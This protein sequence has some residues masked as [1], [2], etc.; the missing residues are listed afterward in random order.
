MIVWSKWRLGA[1]CVRCQPPRLLV[2]SSFSE[3]LDATAVSWRLQ[4]CVEPPLADPDSTL[5]VQEQGNSDAVLDDVACMLGCTR[6]SLHGAL[7]WRLP[8]HALCAR[9]FVSL[10]AP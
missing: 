4:T 9:G 3:V 6:S 1:R 8:L 10:T 2:P 5:F 7:F